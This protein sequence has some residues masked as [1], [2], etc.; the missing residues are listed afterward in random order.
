MRAFSSNW[1]SAYFSNQHHQGNRTARVETH[2][3]VCSQSRIAGAGTQTPQESWMLREAVLRKR[4]RYSS[5]ASMLP[6]RD[7][8]LPV[9]QNPMRRGIARQAQAHT[10]NTHRR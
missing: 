10:W 6:V 8:T 5:S 9:T 7:R 4:R 2:V 1:D 3:E